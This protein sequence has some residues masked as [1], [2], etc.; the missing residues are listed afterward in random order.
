MSAA[1]REPALRL[2][3][4]GLVEEFPI[5]GT[6]LAM[7][8]GNCGAVFKLEDACGSITFESGDVELLCMARRRTAMA[9]GQGVKAHR[10]KAPPPLVYVRTGG[11]AR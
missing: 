10:H 7:I 4:I 3:P 6:G 2:H 11:G 5:S 1:L 9:A 8:V